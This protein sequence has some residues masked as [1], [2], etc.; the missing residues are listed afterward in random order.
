MFWKLVIKWLFLLSEFKMNDMVVFQVSLN[1]DPVKEIL[2]M[3]CKIYILM[4]KVIILRKMQVT[5]KT[6]TPPFV[7]H[8][9]LN[10]NRKKMCGNESHEKETEHIQASSVDLLH[11][12]P[13]FENVNQFINFR[14]FSEFKTST[15]ILLTISMSNWKHI[16]FHENLMW[17]PHYGRYNSGTDRVLFSC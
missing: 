14:K 12:W 8:F 2:K 9:S 17:Q 10:M 4:T 7:N 3:Q 15:Q 1:F 6:F 16:F 11:I 13:F 5:M